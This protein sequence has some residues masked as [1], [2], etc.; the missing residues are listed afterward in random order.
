MHISGHFFCPSALV[1]Y[2]FRAF[3]PID[4]I[5]AAN[6]S[7]GWSK[8]HQHPKSHSRCQKNQIIHSHWQVYLPPFQTVK[9]TIHDIVPVEVA[10]CLSS[11]ICNN[12]TCT[13][14]PGAKTN[15]LQS[16]IV[17][18]L[19]YIDPTMD[20]IFIFKPKVGSLVSFAGVTVESIDAGEGCKALLRL[21]A[22][23]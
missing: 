19:S 21:S 9:K 12:N 14:S 6:Y 13:S 22:E 8:Q 23:N 20:G 4:V 10:L 1:L 5:F 18:F 2:L 16:V 17:L 15:R 11:Q 3:D 7:L